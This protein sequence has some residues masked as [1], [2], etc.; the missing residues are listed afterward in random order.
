MDFPDLVHALGR[1][2]LRLLRHP[3]FHFL[4]LGAVVFALVPE[5]QEQAGGERTRIV[6]SAYR[7]STARDEFGQ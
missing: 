4:A 3:A 6:V 5:R 7:L 2:P 1:S